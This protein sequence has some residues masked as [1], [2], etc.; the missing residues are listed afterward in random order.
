MKFQGH[1]SHSLTFKKGMPQGGILSP[2]L[3]NLLI[4]KLVNLH[5]RNNTTLFSYAD[6]LQLIATGLHQLHTQYALDLI[7]QACNSLGLKINPIK[8]STLNT[9]PSRP[10]DLLSIQ[11]QNIAWVHNAKCLGHI[12]TERYHQKELAYLKKKRTQ[13]RLFAKRK[14]FST[15]IGAGYKILHTFY[16]QAM[17]SIIY[18]TATVTDILFTRPIFQS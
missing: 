5:F 14:L 15:K 1:I 10:Y 2:T 16:I 9:G 18:F 12:F 8:I 11:G 13:S 7:N 3:F 17:R 6:D 4:D